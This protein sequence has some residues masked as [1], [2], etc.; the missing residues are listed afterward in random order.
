MQRGVLALNI[1]NSTAYVIMTKQ[2][3]KGTIGDNISAARIHEYSA[4]LVID[5]I[6][7]PVISSTEEV[8]V[9]VGATGLCHSD[10]HLINGD[11]QKSLPLNLPKTLVMK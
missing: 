8:V 6:K 10:L 4:P 1:S 9:K 7:K 2:I 3:S 5:D 11:W